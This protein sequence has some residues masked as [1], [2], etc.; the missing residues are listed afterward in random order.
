MDPLKKFAWGG[1]YP[2][3]K[4]LWIHACIH[5]CTHPNG[6]VVNLLYISNTVDLYFTQVPNIAK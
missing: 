2:T 3:G 1:T 4:D 6:T 5:S